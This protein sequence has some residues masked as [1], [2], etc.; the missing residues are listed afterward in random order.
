[1][2]AHCTHVSLVGGLEISAGTHS[3]P[4]SAT[5]TASIPVCCAHATPPI[6]TSPAAT[7]DPEPGTSIRD[8]IL[9]GPCSAQPRSVQYAADLVE[10]GDLQVDDPLAGG[11]VPVQPGHDRAHREPVVDRQRLAVHR[12]RE[13]RV[14]VVGQ[15]DQRGPAGPAVVGG[16]QH[17]VGVRVHAGQLEQLGDAHAAP[18][19]V[20]D[21]RPADG[22]RDAVEGDPGLR[23]L[24]GQQVLV[25][26]RHLPVDHAVDAQASS[27]SARSSAP[28]SRCGS[29]RSRR[30][31]SSTARCPRRPRTRPARDPRRRSR[32]DSRSSR[33]LSSTCRRPLPDRPP[34]HRQR[35][36]E[37]ADRPGAQQE[38]AA[39]AVALGGLRRR[40][41]SRPARRSG[42]VSSG[43]QTSQVTRPATTGTRS[44]VVEAGWSQTAAPA[45]TASATKTR[46]RRPPGRGGRGARRTR[47]ARP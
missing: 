32:P 16:L 28:R 10:P 1:M 35:D 39:G 24:A 12:D 43:R 7:S 29:G 36:A 19:G 3:P 40:R 47:R 22:V 23:E 5:S 37:D 41:R 18:P 14:A 30:P 15:R 25:G 2:T 31:A 21:Q 11:D 17:R 42:S 9:T 46:R 45:N 26:Q 33:R 27:R 6:R 44:S 4:S 13:H 38:P 20:A 34:G 8:D